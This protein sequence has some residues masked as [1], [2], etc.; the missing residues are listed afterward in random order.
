MDSQS[1]NSP[2]KSISVMLL[3]EHLCYITCTKSYNG[4]FAYEKCTVR[5][6]RINRRMTFLDTLLLHFGPILILLTGRN[7]NIIFKIFSPFK[8]ISIP[9]VSHFP[10][11][12]MH[13]SC[14]GINK[15]FLKLQIDR[16]KTSRVAQVHL[17][18]LSDALT[19]MSKCIPTAFSP[20]CQQLCKFR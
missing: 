1:T 7:Q 8:L 17:N 3:L 2:C 11:D 18:I 4:H 15:Q 5:G 9:L 14:L 12:Y 10:I 16:S 20:D 19:N 6:E 13:N